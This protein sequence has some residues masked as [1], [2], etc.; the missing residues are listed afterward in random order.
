MIDRLHRMFRG[1]PSARALPDRP[2][3]R[4]NQSF[5][6]GAILR[7]TN[8]FLNAPADNHG[9]RRQFAYRWLQECCTTAACTYVAV[10]FEPSDVTE[11]RR[12]YAFFGAPRWT[13]H[14]ACLQSPALA[15]SQSDL[16]HCKFA[17]EISKADEG[18]AACDRVINDPKTTA[19]N[20]AAAL[21]Q[22]LRMVVGEERSGSRVVGLQRSDPGRPALRRR[23]ISI[24]AMST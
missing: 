1:D 15:D 5:A 16:D 20:R 13:G 23:P 17:G 19:Q 11:N 8:I 9:D 6:S 10:V 22:P 14:I 2:Q 4:E 3:S 24:A 18:I 12:E 21:E 7:G